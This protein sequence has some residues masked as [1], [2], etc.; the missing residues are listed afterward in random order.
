MDARF[1]I[2][3][4]QLVERQYLAIIQPLV[5]KDIQAAKD[6]NSL[7]SY[8]AAATLVIGDP[9]LL[10]GSNRWVK[11]DSSS[12]VLSPALGIITK[13]CAVGQNPEVST[14]CKINGYSNL[15]V[16][17]PVYLA[18]GGG[19]TQTKPLRAQSIGT[20]IASDTIQYAV[21]PAVSDGAK[22]V[23]STDDL[24]VAIDSQ[25]S[26]TDVLMASG[27]Y[28]GNITVKAGVN[29]I[30]TGTNCVVDGN[31]ILMASANAK[32]FVLTAGHYVQQNG[33]KYYV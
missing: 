8:A 20:A 15:V 29:L 22:K 10:N 24:Q 31:V 23:L 27:V 13:G 5:L 17:K 30:G 21:V 12:A 11:A 9:V 4:R 25:T 26:G 6:N 14:T 32:G 28:T 1:S 18:V 33:V 19:V 3:E 7:A 16:G 2:G